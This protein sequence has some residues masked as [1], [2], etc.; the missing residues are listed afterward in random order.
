MRLLPK[1]EIGAAVLHAL[2]TFAEHYLGDCA[3]R[4]IYRVV[5]ERPTQY[6]PGEH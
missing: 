6:P 2:R 3:A 1:G 5:D 4:V